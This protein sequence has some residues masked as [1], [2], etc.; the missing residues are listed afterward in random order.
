ML[1]KKAKESWKGSF[2]KVLAS[3]ERKEFA[4]ARRYYEV[5]YIKAIDDFLKTGK[6]TGFDNLFRV[7]DLS[8]IYRQV[9]VNI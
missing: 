5:E 8:D 4:N 2:D 3:S 1:L 7:A 6:A 9:Y